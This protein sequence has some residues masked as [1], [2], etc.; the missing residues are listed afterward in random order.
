M[1]IISRENLGNGAYQDTIGSCDLARYVAD[2]ELRGCKL[3]FLEEGNDTVMA[4]VH[5]HGN[6]ITIEFGEYL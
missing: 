1:K 2:S 5:T 6:L 3:V 4:R